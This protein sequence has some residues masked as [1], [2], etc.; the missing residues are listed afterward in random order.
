VLFFAPR[1]RAH[2]LGLCA[3]LATAGCAAGPASTTPV[4]VSA[5]PAPVEHTITVGGTATLEIVPDEAC[6]EI[7]LAVRDKSMPNAHSHLRE[8]DE[9]LLR[10]LTKLSGL[11]VE[12]GAVRYAPE[13]E[14]DSAGRSTLVGHVASVQINVRTKD[15]T[16]IPDVVGRAA[17]RGLDRVNVVFYSTTIVARKAEVRTHALEAAQQ[18]AE[19][20]AA[21]LKTPLGEVVTIVEG[22]VRTNGTIEVSN[23]L[24]RQTADV[25]SDIP[26]AP[27]AIP[28]SMSVNVVYRLKSAPGTPS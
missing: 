6:V 4:F 22:D 27:G 12:G 5:Q 23:Y 21:T 16:K 8:N 10:D 18:K 24:N 1:A 19:A 2:W 20:M 25:A 14:T 3:L 7:T 9:S 28:L 17:D 13:Y 15:F 11:V 26:A